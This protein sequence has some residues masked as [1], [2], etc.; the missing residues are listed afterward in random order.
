MPLFPQEAA[1][2]NWCFTINNYTDDDLPVLSPSVKYIIY[3]REIAPKTGTPHLQGYCQLTKKLR[4]KGVS[5]LFPRASL[6]AAKGDLLSNQTYCKKE[7]PDFV[8]LGTPTPSANEQRKL[9]REETCV[10]IRD[11]HKS[12]A[13]SPDEILYRYPAHGK[14]VDLLKRL[15]HTKR[16]V[17]P[18]VLYFYG[19]TGHG[20]TT[21]TRLAIE[22]TYLSS[23]VKAPASNWW[24][25]YD[26]E[27]VVILEEFQS[28]FPLNIFKV[29]L[30]R[31]PFK[32]E[33]K[34]S[35]LWFNSLYVILLSNTAPGDQY[36]KCRQ[37]DRDAFMRRVEGNCYNTD[38][39][40]VTLHEKRVVMREI[41]TAFLKDEVPIVPLTDRVKESP[42]KK[43]PSSL[44]PE[45]PSRKRFLQDPQLPSSKRIW[46]VP[47]PV[48][49]LDQPRIDA[50][51][52]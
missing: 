8:E 32:V 46:K 13:L 29:L 22:A 12:K 34:G 33:I 15:R 35:H 3:G 40:G 30:D 25:G 27:D 28:C 47:L 51:T 50:V 21:T 39:L 43:K 2:R 14:D 42:K 45:K 26:Q 5:K 41:L 36:S 48:T 17:A 7:D 23:Y 20:K 6:I 44:S 31:T 37:P 4:C 49:L 11:L 1:A 18:R 52:D 10:E 16:S 19:P 9:T 38:N 24:D